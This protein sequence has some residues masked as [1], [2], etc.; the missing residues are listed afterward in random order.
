[1]T[2]CFTTSGVMPYGNGAGINLLPAGTEGQSLIMQES[3]FPGW[4]SMEWNDWTP[5]WSAEGSMSIN[6]LDVRKARYIRKGELCIFHIDATMDLGGTASNK[7]FMTLPIS[8]TTFENVYRNLGC[9]SL[10]NNSVWEIGPIN[11][12]I[13]TPGL[14]TVQFQKGNTSNFSLASTTCRGIGI[15]E[16]PETGG[17]I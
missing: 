11:Q 9:Y 10:V 3:G 4:E 8:G 14:D 7:V 5:S 15:Y 1:M 16:V 6:N 12:H 2:I 13:N 17:D